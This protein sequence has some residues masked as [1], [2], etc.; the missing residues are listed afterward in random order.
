MK[1]FLKLVADDLYNRYNGNFERMAIVFPNKR[2][3]LFFNEYLLQ[4]IGDKAIWS[5]AYITISEL[6]EQSS[7]SVVA[8]PVLLVSRL[9]KEYVK[10][11]GSLDTLDSFYYW[12]E[13]LIKDFDDADKNL[14]PAKQL[15]ANI[16][17]LRELGTAKETLDE[18]QKNAIMR[19]FSNFK[20]EEESTIKERFTKVWEVLHPI[21]LSFKEALKKENLAYEGMLYRDVIEKEQD[22][23]LLYDKYIF[24]GFN[25]LNGVENRL[26]D[27]IKRERETLF[28]W[29]YDKH[30]INNPQHE[31]GHFMRK[32][33]QRFPSALPPELFDNIEKE[34]KITFV[35]ANSEN[36]QARYVST[37][38]QNNLSEN[39]IDTAI[40]LCDET[41]LEA[42][43]H[44][45][46]DRAN[47]RPLNHLNVTMGFP[48]SHT[49]IY[50]LVKQIVEL[51]V[52]GYNKKE[53]K[54]TLAAV[55]KILKHPYIVACSD[56]A[57]PL[58]EKLL[59][60]KRFYPTMEELCADDILTTLFTRTED[61]K[62][63]IKNIA[64]LIYTIA[65][66]KASPSETSDDLYEELFGEALLKAHSQTLRLLS[67]LEKDEIQMQQA[68]MG[69]L[70]VRLIL[71]L[72]MPFHG[73]PVVGLQIMG[74]LET[75]NLDFKNIIILA[76]NEGNL[77]KSS[78]DN[79]YIPYNLRRAFGLTMSEHRDSIYAYYF[80]RLLQRAEKV[81]ILYNSSTESKNKGESSRFLLQILG[82]NLYNVE[83]I[84]LEAE[85][86]SDE[87]TPASIHK[88][89]EIMEK[90][91]RRFNRAANKEASLLTPSGINR[92]LTCGLK[93]FY[94]YIMNLAEKEEV[95]TDLKAN[96]FGNIFH[97]AAEQ[98]Y[99]EIIEKNNGTIDKSDFEKYIKTPQYLH[100][101]ID[102]AFVDKFFKKG[103][104]A[105]YNG[106]QFINKG[107]LH[108]FLRRLVRMD[109]AYTPFKYIG[110]EKLVRI[111][112][113]IKTE[114]NENIE[115]N[116]GGIIDRIDVKEKVVNIVDYKTGGGK[117]DTK[118]SLNE[119]FAHE[120]TTSGY[121][122]QAL[123]YSVAILELLSDGKDHS[124]DK[125]LSWIEN[126]KREGASKVIPS[127]LYIH[128]K[129]DA[130]R[131]D[132]IID[133]D[134]K[135]IED[136]AAIKEE[137]MEK[138]QATLQEIF[139]IDTPFAP[140]DDCE[141]CTYCEYKNICG[142]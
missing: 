87:I 25:A 133:M 124:C 74:L 77:P 8:D 83:R 63:W 6:F 10:H 75:R 136:V 71:Q 89:P 131:E 73:E 86:N 2:A 32:N 99:K 139:N 39:E 114:K 26:F 15:F 121:R 108:D 28:Y 30:Y 113:T 140:T 64:A 33:L 125:E 101:F 126:I 118:T 81:T 92:Y 51:Q 12:G 56:K 21:Y 68:S 120:G 129:A 29:D 59:K 36:I 55:E 11:T 122:F 22:I 105:I 103:N 40:V 98:L 31:A 100:K 53:N 57:Y 42:T 14:A 123:L 20:P 17:D 69:N 34:K 102:E 88:S 132:F 48:I 96:D 35:S 16:K 80:Y 128:R 82:S 66:E 47:N 67:L 90:L 5:P 141:R 50:T 4:Q 137:F 61:N 78:N 60:E 13:M 142:R 52:R 94:Y 46:P 45:L 18:E 38:L 107:V 44:S 97:A 58:R 117:K 130:V 72:S 37:W 3:S 41:L 85:Q 23:K 79:S 54:F 1:Q 91:H 116:I 119:I 111:P 104:K 115:L 9:H 93:F 76:A 27:I 19:F 7:E 127:L 106:E 135:P 43:L 138:L 24:I 62:E 112:Y 49:P 110:G 95:S 84:K 134:K 109:S 65:N 70:L